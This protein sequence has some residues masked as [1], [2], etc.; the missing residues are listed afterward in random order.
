[1]C[2]VDLPSGCSKDAGLH[3]RPVLRTEPGTPNTP[4]G[5]RERRGVGGGSEC[6]RNNT[7]RVHSQEIREI[8][9]VR[10]CEEGSEIGVEIFNK[11]EGESDLVTNFLLSLK[12]P[13]NNFTSNTKSSG[14]HSGPKTHRLFESSGSYDNQGPGVKLTVSGHAYRV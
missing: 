10:V 6:G 14:P 5:Q 3:L 8:T 7:P 1:M 12:D 4:F 11:N 9:G 2:V 13:Q